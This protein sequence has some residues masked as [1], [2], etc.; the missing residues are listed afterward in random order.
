MR[1]VALKKSLNRAP[2]RVKQGQ[3]YTPTHGPATHFRATIPITDDGDHQMQFYE[4]K[5]ALAAAV[6]PV[7]SEEIEAAGGYSPASARPVQVGQP[8]LG[9]TGDNPTLVLKRHDWLNITFPSGNRE[10]VVPLVSKFL[11]A[12]K[13]RK[14]GINTYLSSLGWESSA[15]LGWSEGRVECWLS[16]NG[17]S[18]DLVPVDDKLEFFRDLRRLGGKC[19]RLDAAIDVHRSLLGMDLV[20]HAAESGQVVGFRRYVPHRPV[21]SMGT[22]ELEGDQANFGRRGKDGSGRFVRIYDKGLESQGKIDAIRVEVELSGEHAKGWFEILTECDDRQDL[23]KK[24]GQ[25]VV[26][27]ILFADKTNAHQH[28]DR[29]KPLRWWKIIAEL[30][31]T[32]TLKVQRT[33][34]TLERS[35]AWVKR[36]VPVTLARLALAVDQLG[37]CGEQLVQDLVRDLIRVGKRTI[38]DYDR[39]GA[40]DTQ[41]DL[42][43]VLNIATGRP[44]SS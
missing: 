22:K 39:A 42:A 4:L 15:V 34:P 3:S 1:F 26:G 25:I 31:G 35:V 27:S 38:Y 9:I 32:A 33:P 14:G 2:S 7:I 20:H 29:Y 6:R 16:M 23:E 40:R 11:G 36:T 13:T 30:V 19:T 10:Q 17:D 8:P 12:H 24:L 21:K 44:E 5:A 37:M 43:Y 41:I 28:T 18:C